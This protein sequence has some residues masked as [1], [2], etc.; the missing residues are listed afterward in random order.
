MKQKLKGFTIIEVVLVLAIASLIFLMVF[1]A[2]PALQR[3]QRDASLK[4]EANKVLSQLTQYQ[5]SNKGRWPQGDNAGAAAFSS[6]IDATNETWPL[7]FESGTEVSIQTY[8]SGLIASPDAGKI[9]IVT[10]AKCV[11]DPKPAPSNNG[12]NVLVSSARNA[13]VVIQTEAGT[14]DSYV[15]YFCQNT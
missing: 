9:Q 4:S 1:I 13:S 7:T 15:T 3:S 6:Y 14:S 2:L 10:G 12:Q 11:A 8:T 5:S